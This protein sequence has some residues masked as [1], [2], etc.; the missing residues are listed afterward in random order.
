MT[1]L[2]TNNNGI[3][4]LMRHN[5]S[6]IYIRTREKKNFNFTKKKEEASDNKGRETEGIFYLVFYFIYF[7]FGFFITMGFTG[8]PRIT[9]GDRE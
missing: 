4:I 2:S 1:S 7:L 6:S 5:K 8:C 9:M 3:P